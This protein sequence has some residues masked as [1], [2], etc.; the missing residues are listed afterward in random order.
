MSGTAF[1][2]IHDVQEEHGGRIDGARRSP[3][4]AEIDIT[5]LYEDRSLGAS[6]PVDLLLIVDGAFVRASLDW[7]TLNPRLGRRPMDKAAARGFI[8]RNRDR[9]E[10]AIKTNLLAHGVPVD[11]HLVLTADDLR[12]VTKQPPR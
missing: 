8:Y 6:V 1:A 4:R 2:A 3:G 12:Q 5:I 11:R 10:M 9:L 7:T